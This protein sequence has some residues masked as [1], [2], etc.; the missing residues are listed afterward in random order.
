MPSPDSI[1]VQ[2]LNDITT[3][4]VEPVESIDSI[5]VNTI[6]DVDIVTIEDQSPISS[7][8]IDDNQENIIVQVSMVDASAPVQSVNG[9]TGHVVIDYPDISSTPVNH[10]RYHHIQASIPTVQPSGSAWAG[11]YIWTINH[12]LNFFPSVTVFDS[13][14][15]MIEAYVDYDNLNTA[16][17]VMNSAISGYAYLS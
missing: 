11:Y 6:P 14:D 15:N 7:I 2:V 13:G 16:I 1:T 3:I 12:N 17:I 5:A 8:A 4:T 9:K 10:V